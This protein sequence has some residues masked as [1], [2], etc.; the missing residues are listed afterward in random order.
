MNM[1]KEQEFNPLEGWTKE[2]IK[3][4]LKKHTKTE[5]LKIAMQW[6]IIAEQLQMQL[7]ELYTNGEEVNEPTKEDVYDD[8]ETGKS[9]ED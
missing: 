4:T 1:S 6:R 8:T 9:V 5:L 3:S 7:T 2:Q